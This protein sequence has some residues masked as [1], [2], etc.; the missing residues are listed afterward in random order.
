MN[1]DSKKELENLNLL[2]SQT[3]DQNVA[4]TKDIMFNYGPDMVM[5]AYDVLEQM[6]ESFIE[7]DEKAPIKILLYNWATIG[8]N[9]TYSAV[10]QKV[11]DCDE[12]NEDFS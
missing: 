7:E 2:R 8:F 4:F 1:N 6:K 3:N 5:D 11:M 10:F 9:I 12:T